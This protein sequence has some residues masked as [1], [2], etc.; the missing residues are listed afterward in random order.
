MRGP[1]ARFREKGG[2]KNRFYS[3]LTKVIGGRAMVISLAMTYRY[4][5]ILIS[6]YSSD[7]SALYSLSNIMYKNTYKKHLTSTIWYDIITERS[8]MS[9]SV[10]RSGAMFSVKVTQPV[11]AAFY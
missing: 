10:R 3:M 8:G 5:E 2:A 7:V 11:L 6:D 1:H 9:T 4:V